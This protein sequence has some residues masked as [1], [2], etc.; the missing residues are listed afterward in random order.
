MAC[1]A[2]ADP[3]PPSVTVSGQVTQLLQLGAPNVIRVTVRNQQNKLVPFLISNKTVITY[4]GQ[5]GTT[6]SL[7]VGDTVE[8]AV[9]NNFATWLKGWS[10]NPPLNGGGTATIR[11]RR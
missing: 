11:V 6:R 10:V 5:P 7:H 1:S 2:Q 8:A 4:N 3:V 9:A